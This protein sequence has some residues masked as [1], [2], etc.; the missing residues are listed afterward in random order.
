[1]LMQNRIGSIGKITCPVIFHSNSTCYNCSTP[2]YYTAECPVLIICKNCGS[3]GHK[4]IKCMGDPLLYCQY[5]GKPGHN[6]N[7]C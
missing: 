5:C 6:V 2:G 7:I 1:M 3:L 4:A